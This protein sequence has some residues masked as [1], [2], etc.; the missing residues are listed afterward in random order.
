MARDIKR[1][2]LPEELIGARRD[3]RLSPSSIHVLNCCKA[4]WL[5]TRRM[6]PKI[7]LE[8]QESV[9][10]RGLNF[11]EYAENDFDIT[12]VKG[13]HK[14]DESEINELN[15]FADVVKSR[16][17][18]KYPA[19]KEIEIKFPM[20]GSEGKWVINGIIDRR[21]QTPNN[22]VLIVDYK[23]SWMAD[24]FKDKKQLLTYGYIEHKLNNV[25]AEN[26]TV[27][28][29]YVRT[30][31]EFSFAMTQRD[32][33]V[34]EE[35]LI[36]SFKEA[37][38]L[39]D[40]L[41]KPDFD[42]SRI[43]H[44]PNGG[45]CNICPMK[46]MC[47]AYKVVANAEMPAASIEATSSEELYRELGDRLEFESINKARA[48]AIKRALLLRMKE[49]DEYLKKLN[50]EKKIVISPVKT[51]IFRD[52]A[53]KRILPKIISKS[54]K[55]TRFKDMIDT[56]IISEKLDALLGCILPKSFNTK[57]IPSEYMDDVL[58]LRREV[59]TAQYI[60]YKRL[61]NKENDPSIKNKEEDDGII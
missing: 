7:S 44:S 11:H 61:T 52:D 19:E 5:Y 46:G 56:H 2:G 33:A 57:D 38:D 31:E 47:V 58:D 60:K 27:C 49:G 3:V 55:N 41:D 23:T 45:V 1:P 28:I 8:E 43:S 25:P 34:T 12:K 29:D 20:R 36:H 24:L 39:L 9:T 22:G 42:I 48:D 15:E 26:I 53:M 51:L 6:L 35:H 54:I 32:V 59:Q 21:C 17:Y 4:G 37:E 16:S 50:K 14:L 40:E 18:Y 30:K 10:H 13:N